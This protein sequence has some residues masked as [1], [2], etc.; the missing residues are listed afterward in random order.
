MNAVIR[1]TALATILCTCPARAAA[2]NCEE[3]PPVP[4]EAVA[5]HQA[6]G[7][8]VGLAL[9]SGSLH[10][11]A[12]VGVI[13][14][15]ESAGVEVHVVSGTSAGAL[16]GSLWASGM[17]ARD[18]E[19]LALQGNWDDVGRFTPS[20]SGFMSNDRLRRQLETIFAARPIESWPKR[21]AAV[22]TNMANGHRRVFMSG[23]G[24]TAIQASTAVPV[25]F[26]P[27]FIDGEKFADGALVEPVPVDTARSL[28][29]NY[30]IAIDV[31]YRPYEEAVSGIT[32]NAFQAMH[33]LVNT[34]AERELRD[35]D[36]VIRLDVHHL[37]GCGRAALI[38]AGRDA[39]TRA[40]PDLERGLAMRPQVP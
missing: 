32:G 27:V 4:R 30:V 9:G 29:A 3:T 18:V 5:F 1:A 6:K 19:K 39:M 16:I 31:A 38:A 11:L 25:L 20:T 22:A 15:L 7:P 12:H 21:F 35:A 37:M 26:E 8:T 34:L 10:A 17:P 40:L 33:I 28:G 14:A 2:L 24:A 13:E 36:L 23:N